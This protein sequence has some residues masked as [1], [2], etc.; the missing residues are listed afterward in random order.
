MAVSNVKAVFPGDMQKVWEVVTDVK[1]YAWRS[2]LSRTEILSDK[3]FVEYTKEGYATNFII[4]AEEMHKRWEFDMENTNIKGHWIGVFAERED[5][6]EIDFTEDVTA[7][8]F[9]MKP[10]VK[11]YLKKQ[12]ELF[13]SDLKKA[14][15]AQ[16]VS[17]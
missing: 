14:L 10:F 13:I 6:T 11:S 9:F 16:E 4:T 3:Q 5:G 7:K 8:K 1:N 17:S 12:Q 2:D 15:S